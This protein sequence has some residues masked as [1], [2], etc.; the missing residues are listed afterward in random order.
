MVGSNMLL[1]IHRR[2][3]QIKAVLPDIAFGGVSIL[4]VGDLYQL[5]PVGQAPIFSPVTDSY[6]KLY[7]SGSLWVDE[8]QMIELDE[9][10]RQR[11]DTAF[12]EL[13]CRVRT[14]DCTNDDFSV[15]KSREITLDSPNYPIHALHVY[16]LNVDVDNRNILMLNTLAPLSEQFSIDACDA[17]AGQTRHIDLSNLS[18]KRAQTG[19]L[20]SVLK[21]AIGARVM[22]TTNIDVS[23]GLVNG[24]QG[25]VVHI[26]INI[27]N[28]IYKVTHVLVKFDHSRVGA[29]AKRCS[30]FHIYSDA[31]PLTRHETVFLAKGK[32]GSEITRL[33]FPLTLAWATTIHKVQGL[34]LDE[35][36]VDMKGGR[37]CPGQ[38]YVAFSRVKKLDGL[39][40]LNFNPKAIK[41]SQEVKAEMER[42]NNNLLRYLPPFVATTDSYFNIA[43]INIR[44][45]I[46]KLPD[47][48]QDS[49]LKSADVVCFTETWLTHDKNLQ[50]PNC[51]T[52]VRSDRGTANSKG[53]GVMIAVQNIM[54]VSQ[55]SN[56]P[57]SSILIEAT[58][59]ILTM[60]NQQPLLVIL[61]YRSPSVPTS[62]LVSIMSTLL[63]QS[64]ASTMHTIV[65]GDFNDDLLAKPDSR[66]TSLMSSH[67]F[68]QLVHSPTTDN[69]TLLDHV[70]HNSPCHCCRVQVV[71]A[72]YSDHDI[73]YCSLCTGQP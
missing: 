42:L 11:G 40:I 17:V 63:N 13:L 33:Q 55:V 9:I 29:K 69:G 4:A 60:P 44:S 15:L 61:V 72:Y 12:C 27:D 48:E 49:V 7:R 14:A 30:H 6:A 64:A 2:L 66:L 59:A 65:L 23:D 3:Q 31:V 16:R 5:P 26:V 73:I 62:T 41:A 21:L 20:H 28:N 25:E 57:L 53:G 35:I 46:A 56:F 52:I 10:M 68:S 1:E 67:G 32:R 18:D 54:Q 37:F 70:Y 50:L 58:T 47:I 45:I 71:D 38:A 36:V 24:A 51:Q 34:T 43:L 19:G 8:F 22:L 39:H